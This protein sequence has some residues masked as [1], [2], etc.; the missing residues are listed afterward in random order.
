VPD[1][2]TPVAVALAAALTV[3]AV[4]A[5]EPTA[6][7]PCAVVQVVTS[8]GPPSCPLPRLPEILPPWT[9]GATGKP[10]DLLALDDWFLTLPVG[11]PGDPDSIDQPELLDY[12]SEWFDLTPDGGGVV[13]RAPAGGVTTKN[14]KYPR[15]ELREMNGEEKAA[16][17]NTEGTHTLESRQAITQVPRAKPEV[18]ATQIH[19]G[20]DDVLQI[21]LEGSTLVAQYADGKEQ[22]VIDPDYELGTPYDLKIVAADGRILVS[23]NGEQRADIERSGDSWY[24][25]VGAYTQSNP[26]RGDDADAVG[27]VVVY[28]LA[29]EHTG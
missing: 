25:K 6:V 28:S 12:E 21:R 15:S 5:P 26:E 4:A 11:P 18:S 13:F 19:D 17:S 16:W 23:Y 2:L 10:G 1:L 3:P 14:S 24:W 22:V 8:A 7:D 27:E 20:G 9:E 29:V